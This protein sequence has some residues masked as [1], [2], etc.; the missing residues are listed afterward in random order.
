MTLKE[1]MLFDAR[2]DDIPEGESFPWTVKK[3]CLAKKI[4]APN[5]AGKLV[6]I[7]PGR[8]T[9]L[10]CYTAG[11][12]PDN[13]N[14]KYGELVMTDAPY[15]LNTHLQFMLTAHGRVL[16]TGLG[17]GCVTRG[18]LANPRVK[19][20]VVIEREEKVLQLVGQYMP[21][22]RRL[23]IIHAEAEAW[24]KK[25]PR[26]FDCAWHDLWTD[27]TAGEPHLQVKHSALFVAMH[28]KVTFQ[29]AWAFPRDQKRAWQRFAPIL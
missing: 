13:P 2:A 3:F 22:D 4:I 9:Q 29:G 27:T 17:L 23:T 21:K 15:E 19:H 20:V 6:G 10:W 7:P 18:C 5:G 28:G 8:Y 25:S 16:I 26:R 11:S 1:A 24:V 14:T 12:P